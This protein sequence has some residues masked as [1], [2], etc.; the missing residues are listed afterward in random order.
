MQN[1]AR[2]FMEK[3]FKGTHSHLKFQ[4]Y[5]GEPNLGLPSEKNIFASG[6][7]RIVGH[8]KISIY[9]ME[10]VFSPSSKDNNSEGFETEKNLLEDIPLQL[11]VRTDKI[12]IPLHKFQNVQVGAMFPLPKNW[13]SQIIVSINNK[14]IFLGTYGIDGEEKAVQLTECISDQKKLFP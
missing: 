9:M 7:I 1:F 4:S 8:T 14:D 6:Y 13:L 10:K 11:R 5:I 12:R 2:Q 3:L